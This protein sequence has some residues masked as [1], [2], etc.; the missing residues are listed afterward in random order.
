M[1]AASVS[2]TPFNARLGIR[3]IAYGRD[4]LIALG[5]RSDFGQNRPRRALTLTG[6]AAAIGGGWDWHR[7]VRCAARVQRE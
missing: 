5:L 2:D 4:G 3:Q 1:R 6:E 7:Y